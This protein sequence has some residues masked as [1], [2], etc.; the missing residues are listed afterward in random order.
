MIDSMSILDILEWKPTH[1]MNWVYRSSQGNTE[2]K[3]H[4]STPNIH[5]LTW[6]RN[7]SVLVT[8]NS[9]HKRLRWVTSTS[10][11]PHYQMKIES[12]SQIKLCH[13]YRHILNKYSIT[14]TYKTVHTVQSISLTKSWFLLPSANQ[15]ALNNRSTK[16]KCGNILEAEFCYIIISVRQPHIILDQWLDTR[17]LKD[18]A[19]CTILMEESYRYLI[20]LHG[21]Y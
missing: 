14:S 5:E 15:T 2:T 19:L 6:L 11:Q 21:N 16:G 12:I 4:D 17:P 13:T 8:R 1:S 20:L 10:S 9:C 7:L 18:K 3:D